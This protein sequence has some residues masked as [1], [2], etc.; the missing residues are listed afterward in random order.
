[1]LREPSSRAARPA[2]RFFAALR[3][4]RI[5]RPALRFRVNGAQLLAPEYRGVD[6]DEPR[7]HVHAIL[8]PP[9][10]EVEDHPARFQRRPEIA[11]DRKRAE[12]LADL[13]QTLAKLDEHVTGDSLERLGE[14]DVEHRPAIL[15]VGSAAAQRAPPPTTDCRQRNQNPRM[16]STTNSSPAASIATPAFSLVGGIPWVPPAS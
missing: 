2:Q 7:L 6:H 9:A 8:E 5:F 11:P 12:R 16:T 14:L 4:A 15:A 13:V 3:T 1:M 10:L